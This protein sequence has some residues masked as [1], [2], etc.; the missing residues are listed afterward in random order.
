MGIPSIPKINRLLTSVSG[1]ASTDPAAA[2][3]AAITATGATVTPTQRSAI[4][5]FITTGETEGWYSSIKRLY[6]PIWQ[7]AAANAICMKS[8]TTGTFSGSILH[9]AKGVKVN[10]SG[11]GNMNTNTNLGALGIT[12][13][14]YHFALLMPE[15]PEEYYSVPFGVNAINQ[16]AIY[17]FW[18]DGFSHLRIMEKI[19]SGTFITNLPSIMTVGNDSLAGN[20]YFKERLSNGSTGLEIISGS[21]TTAFPSNNLFILGTS[22]T[23][24]GMEQPI[25]AFS[26]STELSSAQDVAYTTAL[27]TLWETT[28]GL[29]LP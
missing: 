22:S 16:N 29:T 21:V 8:L 11:A 27:K 7:L 5:T 24:A 12:K 13:D 3:I 2:Y 14:S 20:L 1:L 15:G 25:G 9:Q 4:N 19:F 23:S 6:L 18:N 28:T 17:A 26:A 10:V